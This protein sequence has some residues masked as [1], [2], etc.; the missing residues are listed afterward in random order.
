MTKDGGLSIDLFGKIGEW[1]E[2][3]MESGIGML[4][5]IFVIIIIMG[6]AIIIASNEKEQE[7]QE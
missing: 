5:V 4:I 1:M 6:A 7:I 3:G 2:W